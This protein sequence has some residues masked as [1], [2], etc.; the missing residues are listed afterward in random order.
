MILVFKVHRVDILH[1]AYVNIIQN[2]CKHRS[3]KLQFNILVSLRYNI[4]LQHTSTI[5]SFDHDP[6]LTSAFFVFLNN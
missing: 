4:S 3:I 5:N 2:E 1:S 6:H